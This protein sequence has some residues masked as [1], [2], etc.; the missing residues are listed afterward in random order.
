M[1]CYQADEQVRPSAFAHRSGK[2]TNMAGIRAQ[3]K[4][5]TRDKVLA[6]ARR[7]FLDRAFEEVGVRE[8]AAD[9][10]VATGTVIAAFG[11]K[12]DLLN[13]IVIEDFV[14]QFDKMEP[15]ALSGMGLLDQ[16]CALAEVSVAHHSSQL[17][18]VRAS[19][20]DSWT[21]D[22]ESERA[23]R[24]AMRPIMVRLC[25][26]L[27]GAAT[28]GEIAADVDVM[29]VAELLVETVLQSY[30][31][32]VYDDIHM[33]E[34]MARIVRPRFAILVDGLAARRASHKAGSDLV[35]GERAA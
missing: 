1:C 16:L 35:A 5:A 10:G 15:L 27:N 28:A 31:K 4:R 17:A 20:A 2:G 18:I 8:I 7:L 30:R 21:R 24:L 12:G 26:V 33:G 19:M 9:A 32:A 3:Q 13:A 22:R 11:S 14:A 29:A 23:V 34:L 6:A 25:D